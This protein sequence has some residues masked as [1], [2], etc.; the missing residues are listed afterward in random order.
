MAARPPAPTPGRVLAQLEKHDVDFS[1]DP[2]DF[3]G[4]GLWKTVPGTT[5][6]AICPEGVEVSFAAPV[7]LVENR[8]S[9]FAGQVRLLI[10]GKPKA[11]SSTE[12]G[13]RVHGTFVPAEG[14]TLEL[15]MTV[16]GLQP[17]PHKFGVQFLACFEQPATLHVPLTLT[18][19]EA[20]QQM[21]RAEEKEAG[22]Q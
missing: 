1:M 4:D 7:S 14:N 10:D 16:R 20:P 6:Q 12:N 15:G 5:L 3:Y 22:Q 11:Q 9:T 21:T 19:R 2:P 13:R 17:G 8:E 18:V